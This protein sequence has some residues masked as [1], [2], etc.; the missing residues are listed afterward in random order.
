MDPGHSKANTREFYV[1]LLQDMIA[2]PLVTHKRP[3]R[4]KRILLT[5]GWEDTNNN[6]NL[7]L[8]SLTFPF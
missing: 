8:F 3:K 5:L 7:I 1:N 6:R 2:G 4:R